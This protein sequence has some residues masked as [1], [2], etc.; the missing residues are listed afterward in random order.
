L[1]NKILGL[2]LIP[3]FMSIGSKHILVISAFKPIE[4]D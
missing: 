1:N 3:I 2:H 4:N